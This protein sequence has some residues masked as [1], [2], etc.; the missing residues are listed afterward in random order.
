MDREYKLYYINELKPGDHIC[1]LYETDEEHKALITPYLKSGLENNEKVFY[2]IDA[3][4]SETVLNYL[5]DDG[6][7][8][9]PYLESG[10]LSMLT[11]N[12]SYMKGNVFDPDG[13][14]DMLTEET[15]KAL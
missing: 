8:V 15:D 4:T 12:E 5:R 1:C 11:V 14:I 9:D 13:M 2:I 7:S 6:V 3:R 10:Q